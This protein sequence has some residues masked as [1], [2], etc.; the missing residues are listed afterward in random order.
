MKLWHLWLRTSCSYPWSWQIVLISMRHLSP[1]HHHHWLQ[2]SLLHQRF[3]KTISL[4]G[5]LSIDLQDFNIHWQITLATWMAPA[6]T[7][8][9]RPYCH[10]L[11]QHRCC[12]LSPCGYLHTWPHTRLPYQVVLFLQSPCPESNSDYSERFPPLPLFYPF[13]LNLWWWTLPSMGNGNA[14]RYCQDFKAQM[15]M[16]IVSFWRRE[17]LGEV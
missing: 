10:H 8:S 6:D 14:W 17:W 3:L 11:R 9:E 2:R 12:F 4:T 1:H 7:L 16:I 13:W 15:T 5:S